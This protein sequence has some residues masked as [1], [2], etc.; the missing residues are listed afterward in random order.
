MKTLNSYPVCFEFLL[1]ASHRPFAAACKFFGLDP[2]SW[3]EFFDQHSGEGSVVCFC[4][5]FAHWQAGFVFGTRVCIDM[6]LTHVL[7][8]VNSSFDTNEN[9]VLRFCYGMSTVLTCMQFRVGGSIVV[10]YRVVSAIVTLVVSLSAW[11]NQ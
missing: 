7:F 9:D 6:T 11:L 3:Q 5:N 1:R 2:A 8:K 10:T 4:L